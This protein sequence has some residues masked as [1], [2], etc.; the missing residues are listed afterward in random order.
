MAASHLKHLT[1]IDWT[2]P[3]DQ[4]PALAEALTSSELVELSFNSSSCSPAFYDALGRGLAEQVASPLATLHIKNRHSRG[5]A[6]YTESLV[7]LFQHALNWKIRCLH[8]DLSHLAWSDDFE[9]FFSR[10]IASN[11]N[12]QWLFLHNCHEFDHGTQMITGLV[13]KAFSWGVGSLDILE[14]INGVDEPD[15]SAWALTLKKRVASNLNRHRRLSGALFQSACKSKRA[16]SRQCI[17]LKALVSV[18]D[19]ARFSFLSANEWRCRE[20]LLSIFPQSS[21]PGGN[22]DALTGQKRKR[23]E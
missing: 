2:F 3:G 9:T 17:L 7:S 5:A 16:A 23:E 14:I 8:L 22:M 11:K 1:A 4:G 21:S 15:D 6:D 13:M 10:F 20:V 18:D 19:S 12:L